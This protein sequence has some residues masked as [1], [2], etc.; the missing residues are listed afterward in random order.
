[1]NHKPGSVTKSQR[2][3]VL[4]FP[5]SRKLQHRLKPTLTAICLEPALQPASLQS[6]RSI[7]RAALLLLDF[8][9]DVV[10]L[11]YFIFR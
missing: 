6:T 3:L 1:M 11:L 7:G 8:A 9:P 10:C 5:D 2:L 4:E